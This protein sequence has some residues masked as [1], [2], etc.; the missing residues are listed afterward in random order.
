MTDST[1]VSE[2]LKTLVAVKGPN[3]SPENFT[4]WVSEVK[5]KNKTPLPVEGKMALTV[6]VPASKGEHVQ[7][8]TKLASSGLKFQAGM[9]VDT[10]VG[11]VE[12]ADE[13]GTAGRVVVPMLKHG[14]QPVGGSEADKLVKE[15]LPTYQE[16]NDTAVKAALV[17]QQN[18]P[19]AVSR[20]PA[21]QELTDIHLP[22]ATGA[23]ASH[24]V[25]SPPALTPSPI[26]HT[27][28][29]VPLVS[30]SPQF[31]TPSPLSSE[32]LVRFLGSVHTV[33][34]KLLWLLLLHPSFGFYT[35][36]KG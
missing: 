34:F 23:T 20:L 31:A 22:E 15:A 21:E 12:G 10:M 1:P 36:L 7:N 19:A 11:V 8:F 30:P 14:W 2:A 18:S 26:P 9:S 5:V 27:F 32:T 29:S 16:L 28:V 33:M 4:L 25:T 17:L 6:E 24:A 35:A 13:D 3:A